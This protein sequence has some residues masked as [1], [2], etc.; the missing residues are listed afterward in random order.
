MTPEEE[1]FIKQ[2]VNLRKSAIRKANLEKAFTEFPEE[3]EDSKQPSV[4][5]VHNDE[6][7]AADLKRKAASEMDKKHVYD[8]LPDEEKRALSVLLNIDSKSAKEKIEAVMEHYGVSKM[9][10]INILADATKHMRDNMSTSEIEEMDEMGD[11]LDGEFSDEE[12]IEAEGEG[13]TPDLD[14]ES[15]EESEDEG[16]LNLKKWD[17]EE[18]GEEEGE[19]KLNLKKWDSKDKK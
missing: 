11:G 16:K 5:D 7:K 15:E 12:E 17:P 14:E 2:T 10:A 1:I 18:D 3:D 13:A 6:S 4:E 19:S 9:G 8:S